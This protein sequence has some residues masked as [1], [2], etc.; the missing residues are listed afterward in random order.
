[1]TIHKALHPSDDVYRIYVSRKD[2]G[3]GLASIED[4]VEASIRRLK[5]YIKKAKKDCDQ[6]NNN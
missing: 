2:G 3:K 5:D 1:M 4:N 6:N